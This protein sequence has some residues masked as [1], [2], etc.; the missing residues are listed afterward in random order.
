MSSEKLVSFVE[1]ILTEN[2]P[3]ADTLKASILAEKV[4]AVLK[5]E[6]VVVA[7]SFT[8]D[9]STEKKT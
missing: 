4:D 2:F 6:Y 5:S 9:F 3:E 1:S 7:E 8:P